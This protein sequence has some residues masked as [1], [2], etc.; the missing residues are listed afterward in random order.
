[1]LF[2]SAGTEIRGEVCETLFV[3][4]VDGSNGHYRSLG[5]F[6]IFS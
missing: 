2:V 6:N 1:V 3:R 4:R 5:G